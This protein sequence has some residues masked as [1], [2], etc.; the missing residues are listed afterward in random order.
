[1]ILRELNDYYQRLVDDPEVDVPRR[2]WSNEKA[3]W[4]IG[5][6]ADGG[7]AYVDPLLT[8][9]GKGARPF[10]VLRVPEHSTRAGS[11]FKPF[12]V[13]LSARHERKTGRGETRCCT[14]FA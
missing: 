1:M 8:G 14:G 13:C 4:E 2:H 10:M 12:F 5:L 11:G 7:V 3:A 6:D 9:E